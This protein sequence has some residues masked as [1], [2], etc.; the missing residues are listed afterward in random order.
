MKPTLHELEQRSKDLE[1]DQ[2]QLTADIARLKEEEAEA[3]KVPWEPKNGTY[4]LDLSGSTCKIMCPRG[5]NHTGD[6]FET[7]K[8]AEK[9]AKFFTFYQRLYQLALECNAKYSGA[10]YTSD[11]IFGNHS[12]NGWTRVS[13]R[14]S[15]VPSSMFT[16]AQAAKAACDIMNRDKWVM[17]TM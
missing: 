8:A 13:R 1:L 14:D 16:S 12:G 15:K 17:P 10:E 9:A 11:V 7:R 6:L 2:A 4:Y 3:A 5:D